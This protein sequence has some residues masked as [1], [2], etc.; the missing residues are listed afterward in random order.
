MTKRPYNT[1]YTGENLNRVAFPMGGMGAGMICLEGTGALSHVSLRG[2]ADIFNEPLMFAALS[3]TAS[4]G[5]QSTRVAR[6]LEGPVPTWKVFGT[7][8]AGNGLG[9]TS[10]GLP[11]FVEATF[12]TRFPFGT[13]TLR[14]PKIPLDVTLTGWSPFTPGDADSSSLPVAALE[15]R[16][17]NPTDAPVDAVFSFHARNFF[18]PPNASS[19]A[20]FAAPGRLYGGASRRARRVQCHRGRHQRRR[21]LRLVP[22]RLVRRAHYCVEDHR[23]GRYAG[24]WP[25]H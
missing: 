5:S 23:G 19:G 14:D 9:G 20:V 4:G 12:E 17:A 22:G 15:Y 18:V 2:H 13:V 21:Q 10:Y 8:G 11:R 7:P 1:P 6:V 3:L 16:F 24:S 25:R